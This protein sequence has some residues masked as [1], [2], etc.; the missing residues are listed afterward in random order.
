MPTSLDGK[1]AAY[2]EDN[3]S[4]PF[5]SFAGLTPWF[6][7]MEQLQ[8]YIA[9]QNEPVDENHGKDRALATVKWEGSFEMLCRDESEHAQYVRETFFE[10]MGN[11][12]ADAAPVPA[13]PSSLLERFA[14]WL[15][16]EPLKFGEV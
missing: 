2:L 11:D 3:D 8:R 15:S 14:E 13:I 1:Y 10:S 4:A 16:S 7:S 9:S 12:S 5:S 6:D